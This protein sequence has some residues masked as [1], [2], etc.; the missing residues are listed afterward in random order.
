MILSI[1]NDSTLA[2]KAIQLDLQQVVAWWAASNN[3]LHGPAQKPFHSASATQTLTTKTIH[4]NKEDAFT[5]PNS[6]TVKLRLQDPSRPQANHQQ[7]LQEISNGD[8]TAKHITLPPVPDLS[9]TTFQGQKI[10]VVHQ[11]S[12]TLQTDASC[13][14]LVQVVPVKIR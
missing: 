10:G 12:I 1:I 6:N 4:L 3:P 5:K 2:I 9:L 14:C 11:I 13:L 7:I 8:T